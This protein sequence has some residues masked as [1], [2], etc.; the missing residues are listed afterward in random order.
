MGNHA[1]TTSFHGG[2]DF[3]G[4]ARRR[5]YRR[6][7]SRTRSPRRRSS[8]TRSRSS[9][10]EDELL[11]LAA[12]IEN[13]L[14]QEGGSELLQAL[15][16]SQESFAQPFPTAAVAAL[17]R[18]PIVP[19]TRAAPVV[20]AA[21]SLA[22]PETARRTK[23][24]GQ[25]I[26]TLPDLLLKNLTK[27]L[28]KGHQTEC[29]L[30]ER[31]SGMIQQ[32]SYRGSTFKGADK[33][34]QMK[35]GATEEVCQNIKQYFQNLG[36]HIFDNYRIIDFL[37]QGTYGMTVL[38]RHLR[39]NERS[40][41][42]IVS[43]NWTSLLTIPEEVQM[44]RAFAAAHLGPE[45][46]EYE[47][48]VLPG[49]NTVLSFIRMAPI[50]VT[51]AQVLR[52]ADF[53]A[54]IEEVP[55]AELTDAIRTEREQ[56]KDAVRTLLEAVMHLAK[57]ISEANL[58]HGDFHN[59]NI[60]LTQLG[61]SNRFEMQVIDFGRALENFSDPITETERYIRMLQQHGFSE[62][63]FHLANELRA[64]VFP[65]T[66]RLRQKEMRKLHN[67][68]EK[69]RGNSEAAQ[70]VAKLDAL[71]EK[72]AAKMLVLEKKGVPEIVKAIQQSDLTIN[73]KPLRQL[74]RGAYEW[75]ASTKNDAG[76]FVA[77]F[78]T[79]KLR[80]DFESHGGEPSVYML[81]GEDD[82]TGV[83]VQRVGDKTLL[84]VLDIDTVTGDQSTATV[85][86][87][88]KTEFPPDTIIRTNREVFAIT[89]VMA[90][91]NKIPYMFDPYE[92]LRDF[93]FNPPTVFKFELLLETLARLQVLPRDEAIYVSIDPFSAVD[94]FAMVVNL[95]TNLVKLVSSA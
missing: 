57:R 66:K 21:V 62:P 49:S 94:A 41:V 76:E 79:D 35:A 75:V 71:A 53:V 63:C 91:E 20:A 19:A 16:F 2:D 68:V 87:A 33:L 24:A 32:F 61:S 43:D 10:D 15:G 30:D 14:E 72:T 28:Q 40:A 17:P 50:D 29:A 52:R 9:L 59:G 12:L 92:A 81:Y 42:K 38:V 58:F 44:Q 86:R 27:L 1:S 69:R 60:A 93:A 89:N 48:V 26:V 8:R 25:I 7:S 88:L 31:V 34:L 45:V 95:T 56:C 77:T 78:E 36:T 22:A 55:E 84:V 4:G 11:I 80:A 23:P 90:E 46:Y 67:V 13:E 51:V 83:Y 47:E 6:R 70:R 5:S 73:G 3:E 65:E 74:L 82:C 64:A 39:T 18:A 85:A 54:Y 37:G